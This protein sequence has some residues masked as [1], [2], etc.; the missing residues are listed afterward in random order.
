[1]PETRA[2]LNSVTLHHTNENSAS[3]PK[4]SPHEM[5]SKGYSLRPET[6]ASVGPWPS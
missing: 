3:D 6:S 1:M 2:T 4:R 5:S